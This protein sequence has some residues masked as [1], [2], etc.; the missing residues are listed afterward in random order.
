MFLGRWWRTVKRRGRCVSQEE[1]SDGFEKE[2]AGA[3]GGGVGYGGLGILSINKSLI[4]STRCEAMCGYE[5]Y[6]C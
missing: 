5:V 6:F 2:A 4:I 1:E 3:R